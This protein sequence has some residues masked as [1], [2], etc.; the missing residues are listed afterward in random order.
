MPLLLWIFVFV[1]YVT[2]TTRIAYYFPRVAGIGSLLAIVNAFMLYI[3]SLTFKL[4]FTANDAPELLAWL[5]R[6]SIIR[7]QQ[8][9]LVT[10]AR[11][12]F[13]Q[14]AVELLIL[15]VGRF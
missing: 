14:L 8:I 7:L 15:L 1:A 12:V 11:I 6:K 4:S 5:N 9:P 2:I 13:F 3:P 10:T